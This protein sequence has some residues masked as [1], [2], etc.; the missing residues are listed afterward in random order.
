MTTCIRDPPPAAATLSICHASNNNVLI[1]QACSNTCW[2]DQLLANACNKKFAKFYWSTS[3]VLIQPKS[4]QSDPVLYSQQVFPHSFRLHISISFSPELVLFYSLNMFF[5]FS[6]QFCLSPGLFV[7]VASW[8]LCIRSTEILLIHLGQKKWMWPSCV[9]FEA[10]FAGTYLC[11][12]SWGL[13][14]T[15]GWWKHTNHCQPQL[16]IP[17][18]RSRSS[19]WTILFIPSLL[20]KGDMTSSQSSDSNC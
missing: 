17:P 14:G 9:K 4:L 20:P 19:T 16:C 7:A 10:V 6:L 3:A 15:A 1:P 11:L 12:Q 13:T 18:V 2:R 8:D 5:V